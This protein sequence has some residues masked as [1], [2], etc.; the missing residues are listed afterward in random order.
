MTG[1]VGAGDTTVTTSVR[2]PLA[3]IAPSDY[4]A[5]ADFCRRADDALS[6][7]LGISIR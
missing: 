5:F 1:A 6:R 7:E 3:R 2:V 4:P